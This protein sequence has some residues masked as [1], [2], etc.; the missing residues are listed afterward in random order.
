MKTMLDSDGSVAS[1]RVAGKWELVGTESMGEGAILSV[2]WRA[3]VRR[4]PA[5]NFVSRLTGLDSTG[6]EGRRGGPRGAAAIIH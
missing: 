1:G 2:S 5:N 3:C 4:A 6:T